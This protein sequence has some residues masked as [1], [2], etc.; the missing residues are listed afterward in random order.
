M[1]QIAQTL[2]ADQRQIIELAYF[3]GLTHSE[4]AEYLGLPLG[5]VKS[6]IRLAFGKLR[7]ALAQPQDD[8]R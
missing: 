6:R 2:P 7:G 8:S 1:L 3:A 4:L 5:T